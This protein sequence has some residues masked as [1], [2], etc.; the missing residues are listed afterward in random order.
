VSAEGLYSVCRRIC[1]SIGK[2]LE[3]SGDDLIEELLRYFPGGFEGTHEKLSQ[4]NLCPCRD[5][6]QTL[7]DYESVGLQLRQHVWLRL[8]VTMKI[9]VIYNMTPWSLMVINLE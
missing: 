4:N 1:E 8:A 3:G 9:I 2:D 5:S 6:N 7:F